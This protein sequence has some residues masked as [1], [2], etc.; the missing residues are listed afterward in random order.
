VFRKLVSWVW[1]LRRLGGVSLFPLVDPVVVARLW[2]NAPRRLDIER[3]PRMSSSCPRTC[4][5][6]GRLTLGG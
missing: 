6:A 3:L 4:E 1:A 5:L 2:E